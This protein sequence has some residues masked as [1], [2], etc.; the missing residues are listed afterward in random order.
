MPRYML[1]MIQPV[2]V[3]P[4]PDVLGPVMQKLGVLRQEL[5]AQGSWVF[6]GGLA[7]PSSTTTLKP[8]GDEVLVIDGPYAE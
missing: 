3:V 7:Q 5:E 4:G 8:Q 2:G 6:A 1:T